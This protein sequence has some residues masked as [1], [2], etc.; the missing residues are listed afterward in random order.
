MHFCEKQGWNY[1]VQEPKVARIGPKTYA[2]NYKYVP[3][4]K[5]RLQHT[6]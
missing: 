6:K 5:I 3:D 1:F 2:D 4:S